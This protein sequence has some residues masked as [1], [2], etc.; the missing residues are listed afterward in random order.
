MSSN[1]AAT[2]TDLQYDLKRVGGISRLI[3][4]KSL[5]LSDRLS[6]EIG[7]KKDTFTT[8]EIHVYYDNSAA[9]TDA[10]DSTLIN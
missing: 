4:D 5:Y 7:K 2:F 1:P 6:R 10:V 3:P 8:P 9:S